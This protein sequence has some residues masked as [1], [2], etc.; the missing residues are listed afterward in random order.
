MTSSADLVRRLA[1]RAFL[2][3]VG[4]SAL[5]LPFARLLSSPA[6]AQTS[7]APK[8]FIVF[9]SPNGTIPEEFAPDGGETDF[10][11][12][13]ILQPLKPYRQRLLV[14]E[15]LD[16]TLGGVFG[17]MESQE[18]SAQERRMAIRKSV[19]DFALED[20]AAVRGK[21]SH[22]DRQLLDSHLGAV[23][24]IGRRLEAPNQ[25][26]T[27]CEAPVMG[28]KLDK[29]RDENFPQILKLQMDIGAMAIACDLTRVVSMQWTKSVGNITMPWLNIGSSRHHDLSH[30][31][32]GN[33]DA[34]Q[35]LIQ[36]N[37][38]YAEQLG[39]LIS[40]LLRRLARSSCC[41]NRNP[42]A[43]PPKS[44]LFSAQ[45]TDVHRV[46]CRGERSTLFLRSREPSGYVPPTVPT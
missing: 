34:K 10:Q 15:G 2:A 14:L 42:D 12:R 3:G 36:V 22:E 8:R 26:G 27:A 41:R 6:R 37:R 30:E 16:M 20:F 21:L 39:Y 33:A 35:K 7:Q 1:R 45:P 19:L 11:L 4:A 9:F 46:R 38:W 44:V 31:G 23:R 25:V 29:D 40:V 32:D 18:A 5:A 43:K 13:R 28:D 17:D 24:A